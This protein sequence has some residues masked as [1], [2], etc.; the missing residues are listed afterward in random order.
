M[1]ICEGQVQYMYSERIKFALTNYQERQ[2][3]NSIY[4]F[5]TG[6]SYSA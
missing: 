5:E 6:L 3:N 4:L 1:S 2:T